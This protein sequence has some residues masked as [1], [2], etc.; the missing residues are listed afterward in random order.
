MGNLKVCEKEPDALRDALGN[1][2]VFGAVETPGVLLPGRVGRG[3]SF[4]GSCIVGG[5]EAPPIRGEWVKERWPGDSTTTSSA[6]AKGK[7]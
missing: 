4:E 1:A 6:S 2:G 5:K 7:E 3:S